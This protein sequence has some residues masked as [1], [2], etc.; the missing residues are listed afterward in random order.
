MELFSLVRFSFGLFLLKV[1]LL[2]ELLFEVSRINSAG[3]LSIM[4]SFLVSSDFL[5]MSSG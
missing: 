1:G 4:F 5:F 2:M 3:K